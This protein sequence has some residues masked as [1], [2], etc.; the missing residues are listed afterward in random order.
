MSANKT[1]VKRFFD[2]IV[3][4]RKLAVI[5]EIIH[6]EYINHGFPFPAKGPDAMRAITEMIV[7][8]FPD[9]KITVQKVIEDGATVATCGYWEGA[10]KGPFMNIPATGK[11]V[12]VEYVD[13]WDIKDG[14][15]FENWVQMDF[16]GLLQKIGAMP[17]N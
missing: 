5:D 15:L 13:V 4:G 8:A 7:G 17:S 16:V 12:K 3:N 1:L 11:T 10:H 6:P 2:E 14:K 9:M